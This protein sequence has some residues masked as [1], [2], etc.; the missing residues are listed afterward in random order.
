MNMLL[1]LSLWFV[2]LI[3]TGGGNTGSFEEQL[4]TDSYDYTTGDYDYTATFDYYYVTGYYSTKN[5]ASCIGQLTPLI[6]LG[7]AVQQIWN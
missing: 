3:S 1:S 2:L 7:L 5:R 4:T 6:L